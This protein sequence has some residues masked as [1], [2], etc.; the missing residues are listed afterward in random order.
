[1]LEDQALEFCLRKVKAQKGRGEKV[2]VQKDEKK[3]RTLIKRI[4]PCPIE[5]LKKISDDSLGKTSN[6]NSFR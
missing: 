2:I 6:S 5:R 4:L 3:S 1:M